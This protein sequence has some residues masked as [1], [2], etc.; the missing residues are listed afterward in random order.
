[1]SLADAALTGYW[2]LPSDRIID[3]ETPEEALVRSVKEDLKLDIEV[4]EP[5]VS[6]SATPSNGSSRPNSPPTTQRPASATR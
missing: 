4:G 1:M 2:V 3:D 5:I 6:N